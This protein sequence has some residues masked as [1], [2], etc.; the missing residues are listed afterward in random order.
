MQNKPSTKAVAL[1]D[2]ATKLSVESFKK[3]TNKYKAFT[4][5]KASVN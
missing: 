4:E 5:N 2:V 3:T 1:V